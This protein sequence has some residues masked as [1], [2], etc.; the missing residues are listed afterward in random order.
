MDIKNFLLFVSIL[1][2]I[3]L[4]GAYWF[5]P[6]QDTYFSMNGGNSNFSADNSSEKNMQFY[7]NMR[8][9]SENI[10]YKIEN[11]PLGEK[12]EMEQAFE[13][14]GNRTILSFYPVNSNHEILVTCQSE[15]KFKGE[16]FIAGEGGP[17][18][19]TSSGNYN[20]IYTGEILLIR[21]SECETPNVAIHELL[22]VL[23]FGH[24]P[25]PSNIM[26]N[27]SKCRQE[28]G[29]DLLDEINRLYS[30]PAYPDISFDNVS[31]FMH[32]RYLN[33]NF[34]VKNIGLNQS[35]KIKVEIYADNELIKSMD[36]E[37]LNAGTGMRITLENFFVN[38]KRIDEI[39]FFADYPLGELEKNNNEIILKVIN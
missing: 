5:I 18:N 15:N 9:L 8:F 29:Q 23:G 31:I 6:F 38:Q 35:E 17:V 4:F 14:V 33:T 2:L 1:F 25:N 39:K 20:V 21:D 30:V 28:I 3:S 19:I 27:I 13:I 10:S 34:T 12:A 37:E 36:I 32:G 7:P 11:C 22:H 24:S 16:L 26:Y